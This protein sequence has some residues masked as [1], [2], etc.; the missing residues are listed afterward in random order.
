MALRA[1]PRCLAHASCKNLPLALALHGLGWSILA[2]VPITPQSPHYHLEA[3]AAVGSWLAEE[4]VFPAIPEKLLPAD[5]RSEKLPLPRFPE[6]KERSQEQKTVTAAKD[7]E[8]TLVDSRALD[9]LRVDSVSLH[10]PTA[11]KVSPALPQVPDR[12]GASILSR[13]QAESRALGRARGGL[14]RIVEVETTR[15]VGG[16]HGPRC[17]PVRTDRRLPRNSQMII[18]RDV[19]Y[20]QDLHDWRSR[21]APAGRARSTNERRRGYPQ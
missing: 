10:P 21:R 2:F 18:E 12:L 5:L 14:G 3:S 15:R 8:V 13:R 16:S 11:T 20:L 17:H 19:G 1:T 4:P 7:N 9:D 6:P